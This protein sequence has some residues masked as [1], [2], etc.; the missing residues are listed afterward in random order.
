MSN[1][2]CIF[3]QKYAMQQAFKTMMGQ[4]NSNQNSP[5]SNTAFS[6]G[7]PFPF[8]PPPP[9]SGAASSSPTPPAS[10]ASFAS[11]PVTVDVSATKVEEPP[12]VNVKKNDT[13]AERVPKKNG[14]IIDSY[15]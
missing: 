12:A 4:M 3:L 8:P 15:F 9:M 11:Q 14:N 6:P 13:E 10:S 1:Y 7:S 2:S 5:F